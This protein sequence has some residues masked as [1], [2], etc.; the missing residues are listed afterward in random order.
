MAF[1][2]DYFFWGGVVGEL[3]ERSYDPTLVILSYLVA[4][5]ASYTSLKLVASM[6]AA[7][8][9]GSGEYHLWLAA[10][11]IALG[12]GIF[13]MHFVAMEAFSLPVAIMYDLGTT[14]LSLVVAVLVSSFALFQIRAEQ[15]SWARVCAGAALMGLGVAAMH[16]TGMAAVF[17]NATLRYHG[18]LYIL[19]IFIAVTVALVAL[20]LLRFVPEVQTRYA[21]SL[22]IGTASIMGM[23]VAGMHYTGMASSHFFVGGSCGWTS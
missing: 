3:L 21:Q 2:D 20:L 4:T 22:H 10:A 6:R 23:A 13:S 19:S 17:T 11:S 1:I 16:Y 14:L 15:L 18:P 9:R 7:F 8:A 12:G 5:F